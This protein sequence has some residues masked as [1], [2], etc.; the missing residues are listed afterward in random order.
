M[1]TPRFVVGGSFGKRTYVRGTQPDIDF[2][3]QFEHTRDELYSLNILE[4]NFKALSDKMDELMKA[5]FG[6]RII[7]AKKCTK[8][9]KYK[10]S[11][12][13]RE[14]EVDLLFV[15]DVRPWELWMANPSSRISLQAGLNCYQIEFVQRHAQNYLEIISKAKEWRDAISGCKKFH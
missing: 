12:G 7:E 6:E 14:V 3:I 9:N 11:R 5:K 2:V 4:A 15:F 8:V 1:G 13:T 10:I